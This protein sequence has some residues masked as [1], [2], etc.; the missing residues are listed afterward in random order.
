MADWNGPAVALPGQN[1]VERIAAQ[2]ACPPDEPSVVADDVQLTYQEL[3]ERANRL[4]RLLIAR[5]A[6]P[7]TPVA[8]V[9]P[10]SAELVVTFLAILRA[11]ACHL[12]LDPT[13]PADRISL[14]LGDATPV[15]VVPRSTVALPAC[16]APVLVLDVPP[17]AAAP[18]R[19]SAA[20]PGDFDHLAPHRRAFPGAVV[21]SDAERIEAEL[22]ADGWDVIPAESVPGRRRMARRP[23]RAVRPVGRR[24]RNRLDGAGKALGRHWRSTSDRVMLRPSISLNSL[25]PRGISC[26][27]SPLPP[28]PVRGIGWKWQSCT[29]VFP[30]RCWTP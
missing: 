9:L 27:E 16:A 21:T 7:E 3:N 18:A 1:L 17:T 15:L 4:A 28:T 26:Q 13:L 24:R 19:Q 25:A 8:A 23:K 29:A 20:D 12:P 5:G 10:R 22:G 6:G 11:G 14:I 2:A 30:S